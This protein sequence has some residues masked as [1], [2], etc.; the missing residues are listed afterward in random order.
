VDTIRALAKELPNLLLAVSSMFAGAAEGWIRFTPEFHV[1]GTFDCLTPEQRDILFIPSTN[2]ANEG[3]LGSF[4]VHIRYHPNSTA[5]SFSNQTRTERNNTESFIKKVCDAAVEKFVMREVR[6]DGK[7]GVRAKFRK[8][9]A[10]L[11]RE[12]AEKGLARRKR[13]QQR[14]KQRPSN[15]RRQT[16][17]STSP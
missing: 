2:D 14:R 6:K 4:R 16:W 17:S 13:R 8:A 12:K 10:A 3:L 1:G 9:W 5:H 11:Q 15:L 7:S